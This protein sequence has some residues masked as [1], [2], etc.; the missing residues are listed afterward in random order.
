MDHMMTPTSER[1]A[2]SAKLRGYGVSIQF[3]NM[4]QQKTLKTYFDE[5]AETNG[6]NECRAWLDKV[7]DSRAEL[8][9]F[10]A[11]RRGKGRNGKYV[12]FLKGS[13]NFSFRFSFDDGPDAIIRFP[14]PGHTAFRDEKVANEVQI[15]EYLSRYTTIPIPRVHSWGLTAESPQQFGPFIIMDYID[16]VLLSTILKQSTESDQEG[17]ILNPKVDNTTLEMLYHQIAIYVLQLSQLT[18]TRIG[19]IS[20]DNASNTWS[21]TR[22]PLTY[23]MNEL[24]TVA[25]YPDEQIPTSPLV[26]ASDYLI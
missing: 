8:L 19:A 20:M 1:Q 10:V 7:F 2:P 21:V 3:T 23:N 15:M 26:C 24:E 9:S 5:I 22:R 13:F 17:V 14:K 12:G 16:G 11:S 18:F 25:G 6:D 4:L